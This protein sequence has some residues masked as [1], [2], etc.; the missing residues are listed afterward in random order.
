MK[1]LI[2]CD[3]GVNRSHTLKSRLQYCG[4]GHD[5]LTA[6]L[7]RN[8]VETLI[9]LAKWSEKII[10]VDKDMWITMPETI[11]HDPN[12]GHKFELWNIGPDIYP[13]PH[14]KELLKIVT[15][16]IEDHP[17]LSIKST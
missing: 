3:E 11:R 15:K 17:E 9:M 7:Y 6:G 12:Y 13:R 1:I 5:I 2:L 4:N 14:N 16:L 8:E 10:I